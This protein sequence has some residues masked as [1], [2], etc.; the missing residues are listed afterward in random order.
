[1]TKATFTP[2]LTTCLANW[3]VRP[4]T[5]D[6][7][8]SFQVLPGPNREQYW[9]DAAKVLVLALQRKVGSS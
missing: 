5:A 8:P 1:M 4:E 3:P 9:A 6:A 2:A 7:G